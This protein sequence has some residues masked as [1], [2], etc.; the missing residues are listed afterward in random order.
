VAQQPAAFALVMADAEPAAAPAA[1]CFRVADRSEETDCQQ[2]CN[3][4]S[5]HDETSFK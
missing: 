5:L 1:A 4:E 2:Q 3:D